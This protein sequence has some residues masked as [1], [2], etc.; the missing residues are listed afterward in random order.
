MKRKSSI[1]RK[2]LL[3]ISLGIFFPLVIIVTVSAI[4]FKQHSLDIAKIEAIAMANKYGDEIKQGLSE[5]FIAANTFADIYNANINDNGTIGFSVEN[6]HRMQKIFLEA[7]NQA[8]VVYTDFLP[9]KIVLPTGLLNKNKVMIGD[10]NDKG[11]FSVWEKWDLEFKSDVIATLKNN[12]GTLLSDPYEDDVKGNKV[13]MISYGKEIKDR[14]EIIGLVGVDFAVDWIQGFIEKA[15]IFDGQADIC[16]ISSDG[17]ITGNNKRKEIVG[18]NIQDLEDCSDTEKSL[19]NSTE[20]QTIFEDGLFKFYVPIKFNENNQVWHVRITVPDRAISKDSM[21]SLIL[22]ILFA[23]SLVFIAILISI[24]YLNKII[25]RLVGLSEVAAQV[26]AGFFNVEFNVG[27]NDEIMTLS[28]SLQNMVDKFKSVIIS[29]KKT[30]NDLYKAGTDLS[31]VAIKLS[32]GASEQASSTEEVSASMQEMT[33][34]IEQ[35][36][37]NSKIA[38]DIA[39]KSAEGIKISSKNV[40]QTTNSMG[41]IANKT[42]VIG[43]IAFQTNILALNAAIEAARAGVYGK[44][45]GVV[46]TEVGKLADSSKKAAS[47]IDDLTN[48][49]FSLAK[50]SG[51]LL[52]QIAPDISKTAQLI[53]E[54]TNAS[55]E[56]RDGTEQINN[57]IQQLNTVTQENA[58]SAESLAI[59]V[60]TL[61]TLADKLNKLIGFFKTDEKSNIEDQPTMINEIEE[62]DLEKSIVEEKPVVDTKHEL[63]SDSDINLNSGFN[64]NLNDNKKD[65]DEFEKF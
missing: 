2:L 1:K 16:I 36:A 49:S 65:D 54:I 23:L 43:D 39:R 29:I 64:L 51:D 18:T 14:D 63:D 38:D 37:E 8:L 6:V 9:K 58:G 50:K 19:I 25:K 40:I 15:S 31:N 47:E 17:I 28:D 26:S 7:N 45:F 11:V 62:K 32:G 12:N 57:A 44:G 10:I 35:N 41:E 46:A 56:Q 52:K 30:T 60:E 33:A 42:S 24:F 13:L 22:R 34:N 55:L 20:N 59:N 27:G 4:K 3:I 21:Q 61:N 48:K 5:V 53:Q